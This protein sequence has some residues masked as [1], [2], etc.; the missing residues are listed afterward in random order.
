[1]KPSAPEPQDL[2]MSCDICLEQV[3]ASEAGNIEAQEYV[4][5]YFGLECYARWS[6]QA[7]PEPLIVRRPRR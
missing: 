4:A 3:P 5:H 1:M 6:A 2:P 7:L